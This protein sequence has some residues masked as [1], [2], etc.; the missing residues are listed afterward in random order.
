MRKNISFPK[1]IEDKLLEYRKLRKTQT[2]K[3]L[4]RETAI[5]ELLRIAL[6]DIQPEKPVEDRLSDIE[7]RL[8]LIE[9]SLR[10][11]Q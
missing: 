3:M 7:Q 11:D 8:G 2:G 4:F 6:S 9:R 10:L 5:T 1:D